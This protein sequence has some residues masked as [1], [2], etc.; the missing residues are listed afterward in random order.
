MTY[1]TGHSIWNKWRSCVVLTGGVT[2]T[3]GVTCLRGTI[4]RIG[5]EFQPGTSPVG[6]TWR[7]C[8]VRRLLTLLAV[9]LTLLTGTLSS[10]SAQDGGTPEA[11]GTAAGSVFYSGDGQEEGI[12]SVAEI[13]DPFEDYE[14]GFTPQRGFHFVMA[15]V[16]IESTSDRAIEANAYGFYLIDTDG[17]FYYPTYLYRST[18]LTEALPDFLGGQIEP[19]QSLS[20]AIFFEVLDGTSPGLIT[21]QP[22]F[23]RLVTAADLRDEPVA[24]GNPVEFLAADGQPAATFTVGDVQIPMEDYANP[25]QRGFEFVGV[26]VTVENISDDVFALEPYTFTYVD[27]QG[28]VY[29]SYGTYRT[30]EAEA[31]L[32]T[33]QYTDLAAGDTITALLTFEVFAGSDPGMVYYSPTSDRQVRLAE[34]GDSVGGVTGAEIVIPV[35]GNTGGEEVT[36]E[37]T[38]ASSPE[39]EEV[40]TWGEDSVENITAWAE[41]FGTLAPVLSGQDIDPEVVRDAA[42]QMADIAAAQKDLDAPE[43]A[44]D[45]NELVIALFE[46]SVGPIND[47]ADAI[48]SGDAT[49]IEDAVAQV[50]VLGSEEYLGPL[51]EVL[52]SLTTTCPALENIG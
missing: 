15:V 10:V 37:A 27:A 33:L 48:E 35:S 9:V 18:E 52:T 38:I 4:A 31:E 12:V 19:G 30:E 49:E 29:T 2:Y 36:P 44:Q 51:D 32:P 25:P 39:C 8:I 24:A 50:A 28:F 11:E 26:E 14:A 16:T 5:S 43:L 41:I 17:F 45:A 46:D 42:D 22:S 7:F 40:I 21:Y 47:L 23:D 34:F 20:G 13:V 1:Q 6:F 3:S